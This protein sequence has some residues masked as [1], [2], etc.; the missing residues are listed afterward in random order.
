MKKQSLLERYLKIYQE[1]SKKSYADFESKQ[2]LFIEWADKK[3][4]REYS[5]TL[6]DIGCGKGILLSVLKQKYKC[7]GLDIDKKTIAS[8][9]RNVKEVTFINSDIKDFN[10]QKKFDI[11]TAIDFIHADDKKSIRRTLS[12]IHKHLREEGLLIFNLPM[13]R[14]MWVNNAT[15]T[16]MI[17]VKRE[18]W[19]W[20]THNCIKNNRFIL[21]KGVLLI[22]GNKIEHELEIVMPEFKYGLLNVNNILNIL[23]II[24]FKTF[25]YNEF[26]KEKW[27]KNSK[28]KPVFVCIKNKFRK[29]ISK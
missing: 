27:K 1:Y 11:I 28:E 9:R 6:L 4:M 20:L 25:V 24:G 2:A 8:A 15:N 16:T 13:C 18:K 14:D 5:K 3:Y 12:Y 29:K 21:E 19:I 23:N 22:K 10:D 7:S 26:I 17:N